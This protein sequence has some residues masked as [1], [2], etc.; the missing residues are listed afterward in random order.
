MSTI[1]KTCTIPCESCGECRPTVEFAERRLYRDT[2][3]ICIRCAKH[4]AE[5]H[6]REQETKWCDGC[7]LYLLSEAFSET[8]R[9]STNRNKYCRQCAMQKEK[10]W[11]DGQKQEK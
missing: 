5:T 10:E 9:N 2:E 8:Q 6:N 3:R 11:N 1:C 4:K 7:R